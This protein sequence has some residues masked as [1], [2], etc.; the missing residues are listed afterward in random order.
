M[1]PFARDLT[2]FL[3]FHYFSLSRLARFSLTRGSY[4]TTRLFKPTLTLLPPYSSPTAH[5]DASPSCPRFSP[6]ARSEASQDG[7]SE[8]VETYD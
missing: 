6:P 3:S 1:E 7:R 2:I 5:D 4:A 8:G